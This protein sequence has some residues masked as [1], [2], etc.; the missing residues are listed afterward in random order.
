MYFVNTP[1]QT[2]RR[3]TSLPGSMR[4]VAQS[5]T[6]TTD[7]FRAQDYLGNILTNL[8]G[9]TV[10]HVKL[11]FYQATRYGVPP[12]YYKLETSTTRR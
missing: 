7:L 5:V 10:L 4:T 2:F 8:Q 11:E 1:D 9:N 12:D 6:N 3:A